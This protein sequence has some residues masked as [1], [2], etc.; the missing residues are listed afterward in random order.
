[1]G[2]DKPTLK[3]YLVICVFE[4]NVWG[5]ADCKRVYVLAYSPTMARD[6]ALEK[7][8]ELTY[9]Y[10][11]WVSTIELLA[12]EMNHDAPNLLVVQEH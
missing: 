8:V 10:V 5:T 3:L 9:K 1:M 12:S 6:L 4:G 7:M 11:D 2:D